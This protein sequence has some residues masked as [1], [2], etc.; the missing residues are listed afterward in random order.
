MNALFVRLLL[1]VPVVL[2]PV[3]AWSTGRDG[4]FPDGSSGWL[5][6]DSGMDGSVNSVAVFQGQ[7]YAG[8]GFR[9]ASGSV[10]DRI[11]RWTG[12]DWQ[13]LPGG[14]ADG[15]IFHVVAF[16]GWLIAAGNFETIGGVAADTLA[17][18][19]GSHWSA[20]P[21][22]LF[23]AVDAIAVHDNQLVV[24][25]TSLA[26][27]AMEHIARWDG[28][29][30]SALGNGLEGGVDGLGVHAGTL[31]AA[32]DLKWPA[33][34]DAIWSWNGTTWSV[35]EDQLDE[36]VYAFGSHAG[37]LVAAGR[38]QS[39]GGISA[40]SIAQWDGTSWVALGAG[41]GNGLGNQR[42]EALCA[43][44]GALWAA[45]FFESAGGAPARHVARWDGAAWSTTGSGTDWS[46]SALA[47]WGG[48]V[49][50]A[51]GFE[52]I[53]DVEVNYIARWQADPVFGNGFD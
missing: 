4:A 45:G 6:F 17:R 30:W 15:G 35:F 8:G 47:S 49:V 1:L 41:L 48:S 38:F 40:N 39:I 36:R 7:L 46:A 52:T 13:A 14:G 51:G 22:H 11:A 19:D 27:G 28:A 42:V 25:G 23:V 53:D 16:R 43:Y 31:Y 12:T 37:R 5:P 26:A 9:N 44:N 18:W 33:S 34:G 29:S 24:A 10:A 2:L 50:V 21:G 3:T 32:S 20:L